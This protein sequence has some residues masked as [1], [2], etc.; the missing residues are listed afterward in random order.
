MIKTLLFVLALFEAAVC[1]IIIDV[2][3]NPEEMG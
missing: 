2:N 3:D 1:K